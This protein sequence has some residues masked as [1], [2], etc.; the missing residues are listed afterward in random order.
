M[1]ANCF[2]TQNQNDFGEF[3]QCQSQLQHL[4]TLQLKGHQMEFSAYKILYTVVE[5]DW[6]G[7]RNFYFSQRFLLFNLPQVL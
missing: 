1:H 5:N 2:T 7:Q 6:Q 4:Y 3:N